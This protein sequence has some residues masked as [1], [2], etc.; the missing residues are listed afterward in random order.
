MP[1]RQVDRR[2]RGDELYNETA[3][4]AAAAAAHR[5]LLRPS[6]ARPSAARPSAAVALHAVGKAFA[7]R[8]E[9]GTHAVV[10]AA[11][12]HIGRRGRAEQQARNGR[13][14]VL[15]GQQ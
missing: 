6:A 8:G 10:R 7:S 2:S 9:E 4:P 1:I 14:A 15:H 12:I 5:R 13:M 11:R 3:V